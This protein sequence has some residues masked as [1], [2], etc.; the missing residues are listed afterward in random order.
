MA[1]LILPMQ[2]YKAKLDQ[3]Y[4][5][6]TEHAWYSH[7][8]EV[9][10]Q[11]KDLSE[12]LSLVLIENG[13]AELQIPG[14]K[15]GYW[16]V[17]YIPNDPLSDPLFYPVQNPDGSIAEP[18]PWLVEQFR[19][20]DMRRPERIKEIREQNE[21]RERDLKKKE[22]ER[23]EENIEEMY[24]HYKSMMNPSYNFGYKG[25]TNKARKSSGKS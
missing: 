1:E 14:S 3:M 18:G 21:K 10:R 9:E 7:L 24:Y 25:W 19:R 17:K 11:L 13:D 4:K 20:N 22:E 8:K 15:A 23:S 6:S 16:H 5:E 2:A 12:N